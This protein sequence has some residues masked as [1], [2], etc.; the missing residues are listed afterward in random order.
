MRQGFT[1]HF[2]NF[3]PKLARIENHGHIEPKDL[4][5]EKVKIL[6]ILKDLI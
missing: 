5:H 1:E 3:N 4:Y 2:Y 6:H